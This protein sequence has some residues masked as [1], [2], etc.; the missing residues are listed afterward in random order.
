MKGEDSG[1][2]DGQVDQPAV[3]PQDGAAQF[4]V[5]NTVHLLMEMA[6]VLSQPQQQQQQLS[7]FPRK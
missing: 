6:K 4:N 1:S 5:E 7:S 2:N 3:P